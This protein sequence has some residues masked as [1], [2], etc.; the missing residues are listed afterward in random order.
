MQIALKN[1][2]NV[3]RKILSRYK[4]LRGDGRV[5]KKFAM[6]LRT[7]HD[8]CVDDE[9]GVYCDRASTYCHDQVYGVAQEKREETAKADRSGQGRLC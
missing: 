4:G 5:F 2:R 8:G 3:F 7:G 1:M 9:P 6:R